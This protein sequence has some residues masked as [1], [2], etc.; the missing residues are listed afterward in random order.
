MAPELSKRIEDAIKGNKVM[1]FMKGTPDFPQCGFSA[2][3]VEIFDR[4]GVPY[5]AMN[6][7]AD[8]ALREGIKEFSKWPT[9]PQ[10]YIDGEFL[11]GCDIAREMYANGELEKLVQPLQ[12]AG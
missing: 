2:V 4:L 6:V 12:A 9:I 8:P 1:I 7:L 11:G 10:V 3:T 5:G